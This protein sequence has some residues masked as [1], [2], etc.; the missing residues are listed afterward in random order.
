MQKGVDGSLLFSASDL[1]AYLGCK[2]RTKLDLDRSNGWDCQRVE[3]DAAS[4]LVQDYGN[5]HEAAYLNA[6]RNSGLSVAEIKKDASLSDQVQATRK[7][8]SDGADVIYQATLLNSPFLGYADFLLRAQGESK[9]GNYHYEIADTKLAKSN[10][11]KFM[12]QLCFYADLLFA[13][14]KVLPKHLHVVLGELDKRGKAKHG[15]ALDAENVVKLPT[16]DYIHYVRTLTKQFQAFTCSPN[17]THPTTVAACQQCGW[18]VHCEAVWEDADHLSRVANIRRSQI[19]KLEAAGIASMSALAELATHADPVEVKGIGKPVLYKLMRQADLQLHPLDPQGQLRVIHIEPSADKPSGFQL[20]PEPD[21]GDLYFDMEGFPHETGGLEYLFGVGHVVRSGSATRLEFRPFW[22]HDR[23]QEKIAFEAF[24]DFVDKHLKQ[25]PNA[26]IYHYAPYEKT[27]IQKLASVHDTRTEMR[28]RLLREGRLVDLYRVVASGVLLAVPGYSIKKVES[29]YRDKRQGNVANAGD[30]IVQ[31]EAYRVAQ[32]LADKQRLLDDIE[33][34]NYDDVES[35]WQLHCW[36]ESIRPTN[37]PRFKPAQL[38]DAEQQQRQVRR[39]EREAKVADAMVKLEGWVGQQETNDQAAAQKLADLLGQLLG[40]YWRCELPGLWRKFERLSADEEDLLDDPDCLAMLTRSGDPTPDAR[41]VR[42]HYSV[43]A[44]ETKLYTDCSVTCLTDGI[45]A[46]N[47]RFD[48]A[49]G[50]VSFTR[51]AGSKPPPQLLSLCAAENFAT[52]PKLEAIYRLIDQLHLQAWGSSALLR[53]LGRLAPRIKDRKT[54]EA[55]CTNTTVSGITDAVRD[56]NGSHLVIQG[57]PGTG[58]TYTAARVI[59]QLLSDGRTVG[60]TANS[61]A[62]INNLLN[63]AYGAAVETDT[64]VSA[65]VVKT[66][67]NLAQGIRVVDSRDINSRTHNLVGG[68]AWLFCRPQQNQS[69]DYLFIDEASQVSLADVVAMGSSARNIILLGDQMQLPQP[70]QG[71]HPG[72]SGLSALDYLMQGHATVPADMGIFL[73]QTYRMHSAVCAPI[74]TAIYEN[75]LISDSSCDQ[76]RLVLANDADPVLQPTGVVYLPVSHQNRSQSA[77]EEAKRIA[78]LYQSLLQQSWIDREGREQHLT[79]ADILVVAP[80]NAQ[81]RGLRKALGEQARV[82][83]VDKF[84]GQEGAVVIVSMTTSD[85]ANLPRSLDF[86]FSK[87]RINVAVSRAKC[88]AVIVASLGLQ[89]VECDKV[90]DMPLLN[91]Y[92]M[93]TA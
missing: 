41:S 7:A 74:S 93:L 75:R 17:D 43:P 77:P 81:V 8:M 25:H 21:A 57:P 2:H 76:Q 19:N 50:T 60:I 23:A 85:A 15:L 52:A 87:N 45:S 63:V 29:Y 5:R 9:F 11:A 68:T 44:Q 51:G 72:D 59:S 27:A 20:L 67:D 73:G 3:P 32:E 33:K 53:M 18:R 6:L 80:Y 65:A 24:M 28:D 12:V 54:G 84:Q 46:A 66:D 89:S 37:T 42:Y 78:E 79:D 35:T 58:K 82:G 55:C 92:S 36:L 70:T 14:Q 49:Q 39:L 34:Y 47:F 90:E 40:F 62:A 64:R 38:D 48:E 69:W 91:F 16:T 30:S 10:R 56:L 31:Y 83:T 61:H 86:L 88:L 22:A 4:R 26:H 71:T 1:V 13:E